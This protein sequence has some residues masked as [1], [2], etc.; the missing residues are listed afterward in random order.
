[1]NWL[2]V[3]ASITLMS[4][5]AACATQHRSAPMPAEIQSRYFEVP[6]LPPTNP[7]PPQIAEQIY[8]SSNIVNG[9]SVERGPYPRD[10]IWLFF[11]DNASQAARQSAID[12]IGG[13]V[14]GGHRFNN[15]G[16]YY[17]RIQQDGTAGPL[18]R[19]IDKLKTLL[20]VK[21]ATPDLELA[22]QPR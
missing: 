11:Q 2:P 13:E 17:V 4:T 6:A 5:V 15:G 7:I 3:L 22:L 18:H 19:A 8:A 14:V 1:M 10:L 16:A 20:Q 9:D 12:S 21:S